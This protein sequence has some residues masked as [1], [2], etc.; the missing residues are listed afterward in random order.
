LTE[1][2]RR[3]FVRGAVGAATW[4]A[5]PGRL[6]LA[7]PA[8]AARPDRYPAIVPG[9]A[10]I[11]HGGD[12]S[13]EQWLHEPG[14]LDEDFRLMEMAAC[15]TFSIGI[16]AWSDLEPE[17]GRFTFDWL[18]RV[19]DG[20]A[21]RGFYAFL[22]T[23]SGAKPRWMSDKY[24][25]V[26][27]I[28][29]DGRREPH[30]GRHNHCFTSPV[31]REKARTINTKLAERYRG[32]KA[33][34]LWHVSNEYN[35]T[36][37]C[38]L[39]LAAF[40]DWL[41]T[42]Y[43]TLEALNLAW[44]T[45]FWSQRFQSWDQIDPRQSPLDGL[46]LDWDR[47]TTHQTADFMKHEATPLRATTPDVPVTTNFMHLNFGG[48]DYHRLAGLCDRISWD[49]YP[50]LHGDES[51]RGVARLAFTHDMFRAM[52]DGL[53][54]ILME[55]TPSSTNWTATPALKRPGQH[56]QEMLIA[57]GHGA[58]TTMYF[59][60]RKGRGATEKFHGA[61]V[62]HDSTSETRVFQDVAKHGVALRR[63]DA[64]VGTTVRPEVAVVYDYETRWALIHSRGPRSG[65]GEKE[66]S[67]TCV[68]HYRPFW[69]LGV[70]VDVIESLAP[71]DTYRLVVAPMLY[72]LKPG[73]FERLQAFVKAGGTLVLTYLSATVNESNLVFRGGLPGGG[74]RKVA[75]VRAEEIDALY[76]GST[77]RIVPAR[78]NALGLTGEHGVREYCERI[79]AEGATVLATY[80]NDFYAG[81]PCLTVNRYGTGRV[82]YLAARPS[83]D[84]L[85]DGMAQAIVRELKI[86]RCLDV[87]LPEGVTVQK[88]TDGKRTFLFLHNTKNAEQAIDLGAQRLTSLVDGRVLGGRVALPAYSSFVLEKA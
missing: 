24:P 23:P 85:H 30:G 75:G 6:V 40:R 8:A 18:D 27:R 49:A 29:A 3:G 80:K 12:W 82:Y 16:F 46:P 44:W 33:L 2:S 21:K 22:A 66:Y 11:L 64:V 38:D 5:L 39:C 76:P 87:D 67:D 34:A 20:L 52:K 73:V 63:L 43:G 14:V 4:L 88:R 61:V 50:M 41:K 9:F 31:Y 84:A 37:Y 59:Q 53:P 83:A 68:E 10:H 26:K 17:E 35:G 47:F 79:H 28:G 7:A 81:E 42:R 72:V 54:T 36:C 57:V 15:N 51:W 1:V 74:L 48:L 32:H 45:S 58:D 62:D 56:E 77:Q 19:M 70:P 65:A 71:F 60:W 25:E 13:P 86:T 78:D 55:S 69:K